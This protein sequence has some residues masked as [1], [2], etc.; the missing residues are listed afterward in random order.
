VAKEKRIGALALAVAE[1]KHALEDAEEELADAS[2]LLADTKDECEGKKKDRD[3]RAKMRT[4]EI[5]AI[6]DAVGMLNDDDALEGFAKA[7]RGA[8]LIQSRAKP[9]PMQTYDAFI[10]LSSSVRLRHRHKREAQAEEPGGAVE[11]LVSGMIYG[12][13][14]VLHD[15][16]VSDEHKKEWC[17]NET[18]INENRLQEKK[19]LIDKL[20]STISDEEDQ[21]ATLAEKI[22]GLKDK[23]NSLD[24]MIFEETELRKK[25]H[26][27]FVDSF[28]TMSTSVHL[29]KKAISRLERF[30]APKK[31]A[32]DR[33]AA[34]DAAFKR[35]GLALLHRK[36]QQAP[37]AA[38]L[39]QEAKLMPE[40]FDVD[41]LQVS[42]Q[43]RSKE[44]AKLPE[45][46]G[47]YVQK[48]GG[49]VI[50]LLYDF[51]GDVKADMAEAEATEKFSTKDYTRIMSEAQA[52][53]VSDLK[54]TNQKTTAKAELDEK[55]VNNKAL[56]EQS[57]KE[58]H[59][60]EMYMAQLEGECSFLVANFEVRHEGRV[61]EEVGLESA[62]SIVTHE[63][64]PSHKEVEEQYEEETTDEEVDEHFP[65]T[66]VAS[67]F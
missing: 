21:S 8:A 65:G 54:A 11:K 58:Q 26:Q 64:P 43:V 7:K 15:E 60:L 37:E 1:G 29:I 57:V 45:T 23:I 59:N 24:K 46:P 41:F 2:K 38:V 32:S 18:E 9:V 19:V 17:V 3:V 56:K 30:Y 51:M 53:R 20:T 40:G 16:D 33:K 22:Q 49:G 13:V 47:A 31:S 10:Q 34:A 62:K 12:M 50:G 63:A 52:T 66:A 55:L 28:A 39:K 27:E 42:S 14:A 25:E 5:A 48:E 67:A 61:D 44:K 4:A 35:E 6:S 36:A